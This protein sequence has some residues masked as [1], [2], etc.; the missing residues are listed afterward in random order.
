MRNLPLKSSCIIFGII[1]GTGWFL[2]PIAW[3]H[4]IIV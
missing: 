3:Q 4:P 2:I 1:F